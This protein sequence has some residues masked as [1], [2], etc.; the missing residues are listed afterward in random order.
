MSP[1]NEDPQ[2]RGTLPKSLKPDT[3]WSSKKNSIVTLSEAGENVT[4]LLMN[5]A[6][7]SSNFE[8]WKPSRVTTPRERS[9]FATASHS[10][11]RYGAAKGMVVGY[12]LRK[13]TGNDVW[14]NTRLTLEDLESVYH[15]KTRCEQKIQV[16]EIKSPIDSN[17]TSLIP[18]FRHIFRNHCQA[19][20]CC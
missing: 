18:A 11:M 3:F 5:L 19:A 8:L 9:E 10:E 17:I 4:R 12:N 15:E 1:K 2:M 7:S 13:F 14:L 20:V 6:A 16:A